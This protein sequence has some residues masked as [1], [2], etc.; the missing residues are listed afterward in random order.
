MEGRKAAEV[1]EGRWE[2]QEVASHAWMKVM[3]DLAGLGMGV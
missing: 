2:V 3:V 1:L